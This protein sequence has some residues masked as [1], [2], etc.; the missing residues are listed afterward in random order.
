M[1]DYDH[2]APTVE[3]LRAT[4]EPFFQMVRAANPDLPILLVSRPDVNQQNRADAAER[5]RRH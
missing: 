4:H 1:L 2:N 3:H 5:P